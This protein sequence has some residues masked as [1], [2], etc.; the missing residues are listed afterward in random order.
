[1]A[2]ELFREATEI[3]ADFAAAWAARAQAV[4]G[5]RETAFWGEIPMEEAHFLARENIDRALAL[6]PELADAYVARGMLFA[7]EYRYDEALASIEQAIAI[8][9]SL[10][11]A[12]NWRGRL[13][14]R[15]GRVRESR[16]S[17]LKALELDPLNGRTA[18]FASWVAIEFYDPEYSEQVLELIRDFP[19]YTED[20]EQFRKTLTE[21][22]SAE[23]YREISASLEN[24]S[25]WQSRFDLFALKEFDESDQPPGMRYP[26]EFLMWQYIS[27]NQLDKAEAQ[28]EKL[29]AE[30]RQAAI[31]L[32][33]RSIML[34]MQGACEE[35]I[36]T[37]DR[38]HNGQ[39]RIY[40]MV[41]PDMDRSNSQLALNHAYCLRQLGRDD[42]ATVIIEKARVY[43]DTLRDNADWGFSQLEAKLLVLDGDPDKAIDVLERA[44]ERYELSW[45]VRYDPVISTLSEHPRFVALFESVDRKIDSLRKELGMPP[46]SI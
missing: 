30:R 40:G 42:E 34:A 15:F 28:Y 35:A 39:L 7:D 5:L 12:W 18:F 3:D 24:S 37:L 11:E 29:S 31:N 46:A 9:P 22:R 17:L 44:L 41:E 36:D 38:A 20:L 19:G 32:E 10:A 26:Y 13:L 23:A 21:P 45:K 27:M 2:L 8:N 33:E 4:I 14:S 16:R 43:V 1:M 6:D 25:R